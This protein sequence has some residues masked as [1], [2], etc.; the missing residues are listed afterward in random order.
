MGPL[1]SGRLALLLVAALAVAARNAAALT[2]TGAQATWYPSIFQVGALSGAGAGWACHL[3]DNA[4]HV[5]AIRGA[6][7]LPA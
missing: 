3:A 7:T 6:G 1:A 5:G 2:I 4:C